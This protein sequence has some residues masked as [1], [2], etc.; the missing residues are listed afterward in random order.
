MS[1]PLLRSGRRARRGATYTLVV[2]SSS[3]LILIT[4][5]LLLRPAGHV[6]EQAAWRSRASQA[7]EAAWAGVTWATRHA[8]LAGDAEVQAALRLF[9]ADVTVDGRAGRTV[10]ERKVSSRARVLDV[11]STVTA[12]LRQVD[13]AWKLA[14]VEVETRTAR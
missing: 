8:Q 3:F 4:G 12:E 13:G 11:E 14:A 10:E 2:L 5:G 6:L 1:E 9:Q 7:R